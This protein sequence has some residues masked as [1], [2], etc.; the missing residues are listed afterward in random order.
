MVSGLEPDYFVNLFQCVI[1]FRI[2]IFREGICSQY[3]K[4]LTI[5]K[6]LQQLSNKQPEQNTPA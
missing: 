5:K 6:L 3:K 2:D 4:I 1:T